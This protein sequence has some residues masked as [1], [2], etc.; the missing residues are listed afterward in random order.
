[1]NT[2]RADVI[3]SQS[4]IRPVKPVLLIVPII[5]L[6]LS[7]GLGFRAVKKFR[8]ELLANLIHNFGNMKGLDIKGIFEKQIA[9]DNSRILGIE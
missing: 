6:H 3:I 1:M 9:E 8:M 5:R 2:G 4:G 7:R